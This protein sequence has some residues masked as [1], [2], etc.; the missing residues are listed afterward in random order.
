M[1]PIVT[2]FS[3]SNPFMVP[4]WVTFAVF[5]KENMMVY[6]KISHKGISKGAT[7]KT[8]QNK[9]PTMSPYEDHNWSTFAEGIN[10]GRPNFLWST[11]IHHY[12]VFVHFLQKRLWSQND[13]VSFRWQGVW[14]RCVDCTEPK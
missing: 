12:S 2:I 6:Q 4:K 3:L 1:T 7:F 5:M 14:Q 10:P 9:S 13:N 11:L 8:H